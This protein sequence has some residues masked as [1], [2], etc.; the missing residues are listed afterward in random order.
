LNSPFVISFAEELEVSKLDPET[1]WQRSDQRY[2]PGHHHPS[3]QCDQTSSTLITCHKPSQP[4]EPLPRSLLSSAL[5]YRVL[6]ASPYDAA[7]SPRL[8]HAP[9][10]RIHRIPTATKHTKCREE[11]RGVS[12][13]GLPSVKTP[14][15]AA[16]QKSS[17]LVLSFAQRWAVLSFYRDSWTVRM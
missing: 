17:F 5:Q 11:L 14:A 8:S 10:P 3:C 4:T 6:C 1:G 13:Q 12:K 7:R 15:K 9:Q 2:L 16:G